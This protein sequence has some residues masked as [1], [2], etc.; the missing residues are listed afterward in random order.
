MR[1]TEELSESEPTPEAQRVLEDIRDTLGTEE[2]PALFRAMASS[3]EYLTTSWAR[4]S[5]IMNDGGAL[6][7]R[8]KEIIGLATAVAQS[9]DYC[10]AFQHV[11]LKQAGVT[12]REIVEV[13]AVAD[14]F[15]GFDAFAHALH[16]DSELRP[17]RLM[18]GDFSLV[19]K[20]IDVNVPYV[21]ESE[22]PIVLRV[23]DEIKAKF[24]IPFVP[25]IFKAMAHVPT[26]LEAKWNSYKALMLHGCL[27]RLTKELVAIAVSA[28]N[29]CYY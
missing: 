9:G 20:E 10:I 25:N 16:V 18:S 7:S 27:P 21:L 17:R 6:R 26:A 28:V 5:A 2:V 24:G 22:D 4:Y 1:I 11:R 12:D 15:E 8:D 14:F 13:L 3:P 23:Y 29:A 19:D